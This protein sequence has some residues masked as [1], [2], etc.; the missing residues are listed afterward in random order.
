MIGPAIGGFVASYSFLMLFILD[1]VASSLTGLLVYL[2]V[3]E[4]LPARPEG[5]KPESMLG[6]FAGYGRV[7]ADGV[8]VGFIVS[9]ILA[10]LVY[11]QLT[12]TLSV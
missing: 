1:T 5:Q 6:S 8:F 3:P 10:V 7:L 11:D 12:S 2:L 9:T 4:T